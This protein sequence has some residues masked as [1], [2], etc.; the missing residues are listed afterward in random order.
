MTWPA[1][2]DSAPGNRVREV[3]ALIVDPQTKAETVLG[4]LE[5]TAD[6]SISGSV[7]V[8]AG[9]TGNRQLVVRAQLFDKTEVRSV[10][11]ASV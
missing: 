6:G 2:L 3:Q 7:D 8:P 4:K 5:I 11:G 9:G 1:E 10:P